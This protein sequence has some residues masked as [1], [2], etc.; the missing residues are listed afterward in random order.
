MRDPSTNIL[1][2]YEDFVTLG[3]SWNDFPKGTLDAGSYP[4]DVPIPLEV[5]F[6]LYPFPEEPTDITWEITDQQGNVLRLKPGNINMNNE[7]IFL[8]LLGFVL[9]RSSISALKCFFLQY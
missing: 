7:N 8:Y 2:E 1:S 5:E 9:I 6:G 3:I 4:L